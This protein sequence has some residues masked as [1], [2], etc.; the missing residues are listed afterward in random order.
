M[1]GVYKKMQEQQLF[2]LNQANGDRMGFTMA[3]RKNSTGI[4]ANQTADM[5]NRR[6]P[7][8]HFVFR[9][10]AAFLVIIW[11]LLVHA[12]EVPT[13]LEAYPWFPDVSVTT[14]YFSVIRSRSL[15]ILAALMLVAAALTAITNRMAAQPAGRRNPSVPLQVSS[16]SG[17]PSAILP[18]ALAGSCVFIVALILST[19][20][21]PWP[22]TALF[23]ISEHY[24][25]FL[26][27]GA[28]LVICFYTMYVFGSMEDRRLLLVWIL[29]GAFIQCLIGLSQMAGHDFWLSAPGQFIM[30]GSTAKA[31]EHS[32]AAEG[33]VVYMSFYNPNYAAVY[34]VLVFP[35]CLWALL[36]AI[37]NPHSLRCKKP[38][39]HPDRRLT[40]AGAGLLTCMVLVCLWGTGSVTAFLILGGSTFCYGLYRILCHL[41]SREKK[42]PSETGNTHKPEA[43]RKAAAIA[44]TGIITAGLFMVCLWA[45]IRNPDSSLYKRLLGKKPAVS[46]KYVAPGEDSVEV[47]WRNT[48]LRLMFESD[49]DRTWFSIMKDT[50]ERYQLSY[51]ETDG[52]FRI[53]KK[54]FEALSFE[55]YTSRG[56]WWIVMYQYKIPWRF[57]KRDADSPWQYITVYQK[58]D[59]PINAAHLPTFGYDNAASGR[60]YIWSRTAPLL[61]SCVLKGSGPD[62]F[63]LVFPQNDYVAKANCGIKML[64]PVISRPH[65][66]YLQTAI[67]LGIPAL[68]GMLAVILAITWS[69]HKRKDTLS[70]ALS[71]SIML[72]LL[73]GITNDSVVVV[74]PIFCAILGMGAAVMKHGNTVF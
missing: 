49:Q 73:M 40:T 35:L 31:A 4:I 50:G 5:R 15:L 26:V 74:T 71:G 6:K 67:Q 51:D 21:S 56:S 57:V 62:T 9:L 59:L 41:F 24:E 12:A 70:A 14:D 23:G 27:I 66:L 16:E 43:G 19:A 34:L 3:K 20:C 69:L 58:P 30:T 68:A 64:I 42:H 47:N 52:R 38:P 44:I 61:G 36:N 11:P 22:T 37:K 29:A 8:G 18:M 32:F 46:L 10:P 48:R 65:N 28:Y 39:V 72:W 13:R 17:K 33:N 54:K 1:P 7:A 25:G 45:V 53:P 60:I 2:A 55:A 63:A